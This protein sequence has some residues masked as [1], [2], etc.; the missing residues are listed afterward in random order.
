M[1]NNDFN[2]KSTYFVPPQAAKNREKLTISKKD[3]LFLLAFFA[4][5][6]IFID[7]AVMHGFNAGFTV[8]FFILFVVF[9]AYLWNKSIKASV[10]SYVCGILSLAGSATFMLSRDIFVNF[11]MVFLVT[12][13]FSIY[14]C[15]ISGTFRNKEGSFKM[16]SDLICGTMVSPFSNISDV[17]YSLNKSV[18][19]NKSILYVI[20]GLAVSVPVLLVIIPLLVSSD[21]AFQGLIS[22]IAKN[23]G[24]YI[25]DAFL[26]ILFIPYVFSY[27]FSKKNNLKTGSETFAKNKKSIRFSPSIVSTTFLCVISITYLVYLFSQ[28]AYFFSAFSGILPEGYEYTASVYA[29]RG[30][31]E[32][33]AICVINIAIISIINIVTKRGS[34]NKVSK[35]LKAAEFFISMFSIVLLTTAMSKMKLNIEIFGLSKYRLLVSMFMVMLLVIILFFVIH[36]FCPKVKYMQP[37]IIF[38]SALFIICAFADMDCVVAKY[39]VNAYS[40]NKIESIDVN[41]LDNLSDSAVPYIIELANDKNDEV[42]QEARN[43]ILYRVEYDFGVNFTVSE[44]GVLEY[45]GIGDLREFNFVKK[46]SNKMICDYYNSLPE[47]MREIQYEYESKESYDVYYETF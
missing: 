1:S 47:D 18:S 23:I 36:I 27:A 32:M 24:I 45:N 30:F 39:N 34:E 22:T 16:L 38:C 21:A 14:I 43:C 20:I 4:S 29:R 2:A 9:T 15:G 5:I 17:S 6:F 44:N 25:A 42:A 8:S 40:N 7:F 10:F 31:F 28:L 3:G 37:I 19:K 26:S 35:P 13:L 11:I 41:Y 33:F 46:L 12:A